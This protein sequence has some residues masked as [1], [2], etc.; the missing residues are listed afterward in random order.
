M[1]SSNSTPGGICLFEASQEQK[2]ALN[3]ELTLG[4]GSCRDQPERSKGTR[5]I[6]SSAKH[7]TFSSDK[8]P[9]ALLREGSTEYWRASEMKK[10]RSPVQD[11]APRLLVLGHCVSHL[12]TPAILS[13]LD[14]NTDRTAPAIPPHP[15]PPTCCKSQN[16]YTLFIVISCDLGVEPLIP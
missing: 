6:Q 2:T 5:P 8:C 11:G 13:L 16:E 14:C 4:W 15:L 10:Q 1:T 7:S 9:S 12:V 3:Q